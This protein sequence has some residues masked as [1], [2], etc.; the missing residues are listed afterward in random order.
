MTA[1]ETPKPSRSQRLLRDAREAAELRRYRTHPDVAALAIERIRTTVGVLTWTGLVLGLLFTMSNVQQFAAS[2]APPWSVPWVIAWFLDPMVSLCLVGVLVAESTLS[3]YQL[4]AGPW[5]RGAKWGLLGATFL[6]NTWASLWNWPPTPASFLLHAVPPLVVWVMAEAITDLRSKLT[7]AVVA[8]HRYATH[9]L[10]T[11]TPDPDGT[12]WPTVGADP[13]VTRTVS[14]VERTAL[15]SPTG[16][17]DQAAPETDHTAVPPAPDRS[18]T[19]EDRRD[20]RDRASRTADRT[21]K[22][23]V[24]RSPAMASATGPDVSD[25]LAAGRTVRDRLATED[26][27]LTRRAL[28]EGLR[29]DG[30]SV[31]TTRATAL[32]SLLKADASSTSADDT[33]DTGSGAQD[34]SEAA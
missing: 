15:P 31:S 7:D 18:T 20:R 29:E 23:P 22:R 6:M 14:A 11:A 33:T 17:G 26:Q 4:T 8:A 13:A 9:A 34:A 21:V 3:R 16:D 25:L 1:N 10:A 28:I 5:V 19:P 32:L 24:D 27:K 2:G 12:T 30:H